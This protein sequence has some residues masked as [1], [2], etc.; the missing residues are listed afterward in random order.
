MAVEQINT[1]RISDISTVQKAMNIC[2][3]ALSKQEYKRLMELINKKY[4]DRIEKYKNGEKLWDFA[5]ST[6]LAVS[7]IKL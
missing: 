1:M 7:G 5:T 3:D 4:D 6:I 2:S